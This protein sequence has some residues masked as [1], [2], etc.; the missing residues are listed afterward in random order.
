MNVIP[1]ITLYQPWASWIMNGWKT[2]ETR[3]HDRFRCLSG[4]IIGIHAGSHF[5]A[6]DQ[7]MKNHYLS[8]DQIEI[9]KEYPTGVFLGTVMVDSFS[10]LNGT[11][12]ERALIDCQKV[13]RYGLSL[14][15]PKCFPS[16]L[17]KGSMGI[18]YFD[19]DTMTKVKK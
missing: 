5:D 8:K 10:K 12:S 7:V 18:W 15:W 17:V 14:S 19:L 9:S 13:E 4:K 2:I 3:T 6:S 11:H 1:V 16:V